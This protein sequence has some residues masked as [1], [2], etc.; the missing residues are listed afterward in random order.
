M[1]MRDIGPMQESF[2]QTMAAIIA[3]KLQ[4]DKM[5]RMALMQNLQAR[6]DAKEAERK[7]KKEKKEARKRAGIG[8]LA[9]DA[10]GLFTKQFQNIENMPTEVQVPQYQNMPFNADTNPNF[11]WSNPNISN[12]TGYKTP[13]NNMTTIPTRFGG[14]GEVL[15]LGNV[16]NPIS[17]VAPSAPTIPSAPSAWNNALGGKDLSGLLKGT[18]GAA[19]S[20]IGS[21]VKAGMGKAGIIGLLLSLLLGNQQE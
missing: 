16:S 3:N 2:G 19:E 9:G 1:A 8:V 4:Q 7:A 21:V 11:G 12:T 14:V 15:N 13:M 10:L 18:S 6:V 5:V 17:T 20:G